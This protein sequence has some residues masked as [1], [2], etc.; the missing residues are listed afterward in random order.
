MT[1]MESRTLPKDP[2]AVA[3]I[4]EAGHAV[5]SV[6]LRTSVRRVDINPGADGREGLTKYRRSG[7][8][9]QGTRDMLERRGATTLAGGA[10]VWL[11]AD[12]RGPRWSPGDWG[13]S[14]TYIYEV[15]GLD[16]PEADYEACWEDFFARAVAILEAHWSVVEAVAAALVAEGVIDRKR[17]VELMNT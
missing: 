5:V 15:V 16:Q 2:R 4:H 3:A 1:A 6:V 10:A 17:L 13:L 7:E 14:M 12:K 11:A 8:P 9:H